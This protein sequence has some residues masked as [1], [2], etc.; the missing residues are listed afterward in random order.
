M[1]MI[2][3]RKQWSA[4]SNARRKKKK[5]IFRIIRV[6]LVGWF[7]KVSAQSLLRKRYHDNERLLRNV[8]KTT[9]VGVDVER[10]N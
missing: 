1:S 5:A 8:R 3:K 9:G 10:R 4:K 7:Q 6:K 2:Y